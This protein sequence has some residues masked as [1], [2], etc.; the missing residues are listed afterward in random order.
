MKIRYLTMVAAV[1]LLGACSS[2]E[3][4]TATKAQTVAPPPPPPA[5]TE[6]GIVAGSE[7]DFVKNVGDRIRFDFDKSS[8]KPEYKDLLVKWSDFLKKYP[9]D[10]LTIEG[11]CDDRG[12]EEY[13]LALGDRR[14]NAVKEF[15]VGQGVAATRLKTISYGKDRPEVAGDNEAAWAANR[16]A[17]G[18]I[19]Q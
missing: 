12:T 2:D 10:A 3:T 13:N 4:A 1:A 7:E 14:A 6:R 9:A 8:V 17:V 11:Y 15:L 19:G 18:V 16:R 5:M